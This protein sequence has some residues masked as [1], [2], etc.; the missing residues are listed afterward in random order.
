MRDFS[1]IS[2]EMR[3]LEKTLEYHSRLYYELDEPVIQD[4][5]YDALFRRLKDLERDYPQFTN[6]NSPTQRV[7]G[8]VSEGFQKVRH[9]VP[10]GSFADI[11]SEEELFD[12][13]NKIKKDFPE[14]DF[15]I[16]EVSVCPYEA[17][18]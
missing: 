1:E 12:F 10:M 2:S 13:V 18:E 5:E 8:K 4:E 15:I 6:P 9:A 16:S 11:F 3:D 14:A 7:G 17:I